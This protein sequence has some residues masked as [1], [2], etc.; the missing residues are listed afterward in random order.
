MSKTV[1]STDQAP[2]A[3]G[4]YS[5]A[6]VHGDLVFCAGQI[7][8]DPATGQIVEGDTVVQANRVVQNMKA[9]L[10]AAGS[11]IEKILKLEVFLTDLSDFPRVNSYLAEIFTE[12]FPARV[13]IGVAA[14]PMGA[15]V[16]MAAT[17]TR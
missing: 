10:E 11:S 9:V 17:A 3:I 15:E 2:A 12:D 4:P 1:I 14:L 13:T 8:L 6:V 16:E 7:P 5:Q